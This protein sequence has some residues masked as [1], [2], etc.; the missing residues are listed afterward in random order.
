MR[1]MHTVE[2]LEQAIAVA[3]SCGIGVRQDWFAGAASGVCQ[4]KGRDWVFVDLALSAQEQ[5]EQVL[6]AL[7]G[8]PELE[9][10]VFSPGLRNLLNARRVA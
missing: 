4:F 6:S 7:R 1:I 9:H 8:R 2:L 10:I 3:H 5:L